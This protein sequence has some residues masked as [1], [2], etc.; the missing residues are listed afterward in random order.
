MADFFKQILDL[1]KQIPVFLGTFD[2]ELVLLLFALCFLGELLLASV[3]YL[4]ETVWLVAGFNLASG[5]LSVLQFLILWLAA[6]AGREAGV[7]LLF[8]VSRLGS[9][10]LTRLYQKYL[11]KRFKKFSG[12]DNWMAKISKKLDTRLSP[13][14]IA[15]GRLIGLGTPLTVLLGVKKHYKELF[16]GVLMSSL[17]FDGMFVIVGM[18]VGKNT[19][20]K[21]WEKVVFSLIG[22]T[23]FYS[24]VFGI[25]QVTK[26]FKNRAALK[27]APAKTSPEE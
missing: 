14:T 19:M 25:Q 7:L 6:V 16:F 8:S 27:N 3:P 11:E 15:M 2:L 10:P 4:L 20:L 23:V 1:L 17:V 26:Y 18:V 5:N 9:L 22:L 13:F 12:K 24:V 21:P